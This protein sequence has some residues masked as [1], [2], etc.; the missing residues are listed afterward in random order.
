MMKGAGGYPGLAGDFTNG[1]SG[2]ALL[3]HTLIK[4]LDD[5]CAA[6]ICDAFS[7]HALFHSSH[8]MDKLIGRMTNLLPS[9]RSLSTFFIFFLFYFYRNHV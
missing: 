8:C 3:H 4:C 9:N 5:L 6:F 2:S 1:S 7:A